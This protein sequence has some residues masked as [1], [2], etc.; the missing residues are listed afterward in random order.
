MA[1]I[2]GSGSLTWLRTPRL[3]S[4]T[5]T[6]NVE[7]NHPL[8]IAANLVAATV[9]RLRDLG[10]LLQVARGTGHVAL[11]VARGDRLAPVVE[12]A[13]ARESDLNF[14]PAV[15]EIES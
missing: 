7:T 10:V 15:L 1:F 3:A 13:A 2:F 5:R 14:G 11:R 12:L 6:T 4:F 8:E 9:Y